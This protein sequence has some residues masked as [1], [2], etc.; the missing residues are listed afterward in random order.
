MAIIG[1]HP[2]HRY[3]DSHKDFGENSFRISFSDP[4]NWIN[5]GLFCRTS[6]H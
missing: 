3:K 1:T 2:D 4:S 5:R 6:I